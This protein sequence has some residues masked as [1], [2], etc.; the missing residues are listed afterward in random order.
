M[1]SRSKFVKFSNPLRKISEHYIE[2]E[3]LCAEREIPLSSDLWIHTEMP[4]KRNITRQLH[5]LDMLSLE[6]RS[7]D[8]SFGNNYLW[9]DYFYIYLRLSFFM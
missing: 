9:K 2:E 1:F 4:E 5:W 6:G 8:R 3:E 7:G